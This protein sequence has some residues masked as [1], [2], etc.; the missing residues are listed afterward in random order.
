MIE[1]ACV[2]PPVQYNVSFTSVL[3]NNTGG[4]CPKASSGSKTES[5]KRE[6]DADRNEENDTSETLCRR[7]GSILGGKEE[8]AVTSQLVATNETNCEEQNRRCEE[9]HR[10]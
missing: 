5:S 3:V 1:Q 8:G 4:A 10:K 6:K 7:L 9:F 2:Q